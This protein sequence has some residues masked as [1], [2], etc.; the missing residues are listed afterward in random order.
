[1]RPIVRARLP[2][3][4]TAEPTTVTHSFQR[5]QHAVSELFRLGF[6]KIDLIMA[7]N[8]QDWK[9]EDEDDGDQEIDETVICANT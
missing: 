8:G 7:E 2:G 1:M 4:A 3:V 9:R 6:D 5:V